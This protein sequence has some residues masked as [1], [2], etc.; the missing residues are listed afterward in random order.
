[1]LLPPLFAFSGAIAAYL[2]SRRIPD[3]ALGIVLKIGASCCILVGVIISHWLLKAGV[4][5]A[6]L[7]VPICDRTLASFQDARSS[8]PSLCWR[9]RNCDFDK[10]SGNQ[11]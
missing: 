3:E 1:M 11:L 5:L 6:F 8:C 9:Q 4:L 2:L 10:R 7:V